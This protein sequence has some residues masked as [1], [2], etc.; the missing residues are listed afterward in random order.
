MGKVKVAHWI[1]RL[2]FTLPCRGLVI[3]WAPGI[4]FQ[5]FKIS[6][7]VTLIGVTKP[8]MDQI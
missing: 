5:N 7:F 6:K 1:T 2:P 3:Y 4:D 8:H